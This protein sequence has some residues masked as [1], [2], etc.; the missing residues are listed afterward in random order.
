MFT[1]IIEEI[2][3]LRR[4]QKQGQA[5][6]LTVE[7]KTVLTDV[8][9]GDSIAVN[10]V[11]L[12]VVAFDG[13]SF[14]VDVMPETY[15]KTTLKQL[16]VGS[17]VNLE[18]AMPAN[19]RFGG[20]LVQGHVDAM[21]RIVSRRQEENAVVFVIEPLQGGLMKYMLPNGSITIDGISLTLVNVTETTLT[22]SIIPHTLAETVLQDK[23]PGDV[24]N[25]E[26][27]LL[28]KYVERLLLFRGAESS[29]PGSTPS[30]ASTGGVTEDFLARHGFL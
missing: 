16:A 12:T 4:V 11:C 19:G 2:G 29:G 9:L 21:G 30:A 13:G 10:G 22:V 15:R 18:R 28:G 23:N 7:A 1:G 5:M 26:C 25:L 8:K 17:R 6:V 27:D 24:V 3:R 14:T 20:H